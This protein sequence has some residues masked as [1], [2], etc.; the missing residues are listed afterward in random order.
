MDEKNFGFG[1]FNDDEPQFTKIKKQ[2]QRKKK[3]N[4]ILKIVIAVIVVSLVVFF[5]YKL[6]LNIQ[7]SRVN[8]DNEVLYTPSSDLKCTS[9]KNTFVTTTV[10]GVKMVNQKGE[11]VFLEVSDAVSPYVKG[12]TD[13]VFLTNKKTVLCYDI[14]GKTA[15]LFSESGVIETYNFRKKIIKAK[16]NKDGRFVIITEEDGSKAAV[17][18]Y[19]ND[20]SEIMIWYSG[21]GYVVDAQ[22][23]DEKSSMAVLTNE[24]NKSKISSKILFFT[25]DSAE[26]YMGKII[27]EST[28]CSL[29]YS[30]ECAYII[31]NDCVYFIDNDGDMNKISD[32]SDKK[33]KHFKSFS[34]GNLMLCYTS[35]TDEKYNVDVFNKNGKR[36]S[37]FTVESFLSICDISEDRFLILKRKG[38]V[39]VSSRGR[40]LKELS[41][42]YDVKTACYYKDKIAVLSQDKIFFY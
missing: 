14:K 22:I 40:L 3:K 2:K 25:F 34:N 36:I 5:G 9:F 33:M 35:P 30:G 18:V 29:S 7:K 32:F 24:V 42:D 16:M 26:P 21:T 10:D 13:A 11:D 28:A 6:F 15:I 37:S 1:S 8:T 17:R 41:C 4:T 19:N 31:C 38:V 27:S 20:G 12:M 23:S 39:S